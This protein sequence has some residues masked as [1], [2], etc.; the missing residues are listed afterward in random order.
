M[1]VTG[2]TNGG[3]VAIGA[4]YIG[5]GFT[6]LMTIVVVAGIGLVVDWLAGSTPLFLIVG[7]VLGFG[8]GLYYLYRTLK[9]MGDS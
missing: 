7:I 6:F 2:I 8:L 3:G 4:G 9:D 1:E 5:A